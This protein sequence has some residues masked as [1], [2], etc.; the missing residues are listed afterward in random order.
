MN[1][2]EKIIYDAIAHA[3]GEEVMALSDEDPLLEKLEFDSF[4]TVMFLLELDSQ[5]PGKLELQKFD[6]QITFGALKRLLA[7]EA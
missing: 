6:R 2:V 4:T 1:E 5:F 3:N 7:G